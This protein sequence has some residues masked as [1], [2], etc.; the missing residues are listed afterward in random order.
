MSEWLV[1]VYKI[2]PEPTRL[3]AG[4]WRQL[5]AAGAI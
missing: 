5:K 4:I 3:R 2:P 1:L